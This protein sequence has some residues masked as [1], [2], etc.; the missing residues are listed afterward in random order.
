[1]CF[2]KIITIQQWRL[3]QLELNKGFLHDDIVEGVYMELPPFKPKE[4]TKL[5]IFGWLKT[6]LKWFIKFFYPF[7]MFDTSNQI[8]IIHCLFDQKELALLLYLY[9]S[10][11]RL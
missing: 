11:M 9:I 4:E 5:C 3:Y 10:M 6:S 1:M 8:L 7:E 2:L